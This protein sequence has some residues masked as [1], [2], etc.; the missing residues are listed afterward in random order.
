MKFSGFQEYKTGVLIP[1]F[2]LRSDQSCGCGEFLD[3][4]TLADWCIKSGLN[5]IQ[6]LPVND[7]GDDASPYNALSAFALHPLFIRLDVLPE[8]KDLTTAGKKSINAAISTLREA[9]EKHATMEYKQV[10]DGKLDILFELFKLAKNSIIA[11]TA[12]ATWMKSN[13]WVREYAAFR[14]LK[15][16]HNSAGWQSWR[17]EYRHGNAD[18]VTRVWKDSALGEK[19]QFHA[20]VQWRLE[21]QFR[22]VAE[23][24]GKLGIMLKGDIPI[25]MN[26]DSADVWAHGNVFHLEQRA[27]A[28]PD[29]FAA[30]GQNWGFPIYNWDYLASHD[31][32]WWRE[33]LLQ[34]DKF[35]HAYRIDHVLG[36]FRIWT[37]DKHHQ[38]GLLGYFKPS[39]YISRNDLHGIGFDDGRIR[40][41]SEPHIHGGRLH[42][43]FGMRSIE[44]I[45]RCF[46]RIG[47]EDLYLFKPEIRGEKN[48]NDLPLI[49]QERQHLL[50][51]YR[52][53]ALLNVDEGLFCTTW[54]FRNCDRYQSLSDSERWVFEELVA[55]RAKESEELWQKN[56]E[57]LLRFMIETVPMLTCAEDLG[58][59]PDC[60]P[61]T[62]SGLGILG[63]KIP[64]WAREW[65][66]NGQPYIRIEDYPFLSVC[67][68]SVH[69]TSTLRE[70]WEREQDKWGFW[71]A[72]QFPGACPDQYSA[73][74]ARIVITRMLSAG[75][76]LCMF[77]IQDL[78]A[79]DNR[80][81][82]ADAA[83][84]RINV[85]GTVQKS[86][87]AYR[88]PMTLES[89]VADGG[90]SGMLNSLTAE[91][92]KK[93]LPASAPHVVAKVKAKK[94]KE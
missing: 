54:T 23:Y 41:L 68:P 60:V 61:H 35:Y 32:S 13:P 6:L 82:V 56:G 72:M 29:M 45:G 30:M 28:P 34:A 67:A 22:D 50:D 10:L 11:D 85:P 86:N 9:T 55:K 75:S 64:R 76:A 73:D 58:V 27:G 39:I 79:L 40:W 16:L 43:I 42:E 12:L 8:L 66:K 48:F 52:N 5:I 3:L 37:I 57:K 59:V 91:R 25:M 74:T 1:V 17:A 90:F 33:R 63:L 84:E 65:S 46:N 81:R 49:D 88:L 44:I 87:W 20:W 31:Y 80:Y 47:N 93:P 18:V 77:Q 15:S 89:L 71:D 92:V 51:M 62:L 2:T 26:E 53:R 94:S 7:T 70:W 78:F 14:T 38:E 69:D 24:V 21:A 19:A 4:K 83:S 36:F